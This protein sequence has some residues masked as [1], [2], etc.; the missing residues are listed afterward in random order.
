[1]AITSERL[2][3]I[4]RAITMGDNAGAR[5][6]DALAKTHADMAKEKRQERADLQRELKERA[7][8]ERAT[9]ERGGLGS[10][11]QQGAVAPNPRH[12]PDTPPRRERCRSSAASRDR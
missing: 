9:T 7:K 12:R 1:M 2:A 8:D 11:A 4:S 10:A 3:G 6:D 5:Q